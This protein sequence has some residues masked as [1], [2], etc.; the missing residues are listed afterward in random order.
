MARFM[1]YVAARRFVSISVVQIKKVKLRTSQSDA[2]ILR[3]VN[4][5]SMLN[6]PYIVR[7]YAT[8][9]ET[10]HGESGSPT[11]SES[12]ASTSIV[13]SGHTRSV[14]FEDDPFKIDLDDLTKSRS[15][16]KSFPSIHF[17]Y[18]DDDE[19]PDEGDQDESSGAMAASTDTLGQRHGLQRTLYIS[20]ACLLG[21][22]SYPAKRF[23]RNLLKSRR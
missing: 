23:S 8:W 1:L 16:T 5:L 20:M 3:E 2:K 18:D 22:H 15:A 14:R 9:M 17:G 4:T 13:E 19:A 21:L 12:D 7:Y 11:D 6:H 10:S